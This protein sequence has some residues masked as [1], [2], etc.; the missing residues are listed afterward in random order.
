M[1]RMSYVYLLLSILLIASPIIPAYSA[2][3][4]T[5][6]VT[7]DR[8]I[9]NIG[10]SVVIAVRVSED[11]S[12]K[13]LV[14]TPAGTVTYNLGSVGYGYWYTF[15]ASGLTSV[16]GTYTVQVAASF[17]GWGG[18]TYTASTLFYVQGPPFDFS[19]SLSPASKTVE[20]GGTASF[21]ILVTYSSPAYSGVVINVKISGLG[22]GMGW[23][24]GTSD[25]LHIST[26]PT[27]PAQTYTIVLVGTARGISRQTTAILVVV[28]RFDFSLTVNPQV[29]TVSIGEKTSYTVTVNLL[30]GSPAV[31]SLNISGLPAELK[32]I[33]SPQTGTPTFTSILTLDATSASTEAN[34][35]LTISAS[36]RGA[37]K[38]AT[39]TLSVKREDFT[40]TCP[41]KQTS[42]R[43]GQK[44]S[45][46]LDVKPL[47]RFD[48][49]VD[50]TVLGM[51]DGVTSTLTVSS[52]KPPFASE[53]MVEAGPTAKVGKYV[54][55]IRAAGKGKTHS[56]TVALNINKMASSLEISLGQ[57]WFG[58][59][60]VTGTM[61][62]PVEGSEIDLIYHGPGEKTVTRKT[63]VDREGR[64]KDVYSPD[65]SGNWTVVAIWL[66]NEDVESSSSNKISFQKTSYLPAFLSNQL[67]L[68][69]IAA[70]VAVSAIGGVFLRRRRTFRPSHVEPQLSICPKCGAPVGND[71]L[72]CSSCGE[73]VRKPEP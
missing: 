28:P 42:V 50:L 23:R 67:V 64:F 72:F 10:D 29:Q 65:E 52:G 35:T 3:A 55:T 38:V 14:S 25:D 43:K 7:T 44:T 54:I 58:D 70:A 18:A 5:V 73:I 19:I 21:Q 20:Q 59:F 24:L 49:I 36:S 53:L 45:L 15:T 41:V 56:L 16:P 47:G 26:S 61:K 32:H 39:V 11:A 33:F 69:I 48:E 4:P 66:G 71:D 13:V 17:P 34:Y 8:S 1:S 51:P 2:M 30:S 68:I 12:V 22:P 46:N 63:H 27:T 31:V 37:S 60:T 62:P 9:Y 40:L 6:E 57:G